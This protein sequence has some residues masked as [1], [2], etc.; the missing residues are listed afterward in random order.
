M[1]NIGPGLDAASWLSW[2]WPEAQ[3]HP[4][5]WGAHTNLLAWAL[6]CEGNVF[7]LLRGH[8]SEEFLLLTC[9]A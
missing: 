3:G 6:V 9:A 7:L 1:G 5:H 4:Q 8:I 2:I